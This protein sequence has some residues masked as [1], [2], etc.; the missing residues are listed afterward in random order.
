MQPPRYRVEFL[1]KS[2]TEMRDVLSPIPGFI[3]TIYVNDKQTM[4][5]KTEYL[6]ERLNPSITIAWDRFIRVMVEKDGDQ[7]VLTIKNGDTHQS[8]QWYN[9]YAQAYGLWDAIATGLG[10][11]HR[12][13]AQDMWAYEPDEYTEQEMEQLRDDV[14]DG[15]V[16]GHM[17][18]AKVVE[19]RIEWQDPPQVWVRVVR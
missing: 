5:D 18:R 7:Y 16:I 2:L 11:S 19:T 3:A 14:M 4:C 12:Q 13:D 15:D 8:K 6:L 10:L 17:G 1:C 9:S